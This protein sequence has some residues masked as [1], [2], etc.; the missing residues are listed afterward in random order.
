[1][2]VSHRYRDFGGPKKTSGADNSSVSEEL[3]D[4]KLKAFEAGYQAG[5][6]DSLKAKEGAQEKLQTELSQSLLD[7]SFTYHEAL[8]KLTTSFEAV[9][10]EVVSKLLPEVV[11]TS[12]GAHIVEQTKQMLAAKTGQ[13]VEIVVNPE[14]SAV[15]EQILGEH[16]DNP[17]A[18]V[19]E[20]TLSAG[21][22]FI[23][24]S[25]N[26][27]QIDLDTVIS[28]VSRALNGFFHETAKEAKNGQ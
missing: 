24:V 13:S 22:A 19:S 28:E 25:D 3:E 17:F 1:M 16:L 10:T 27:C 14:N 26:E 18:L 21:Q 23:R 7:A 8:A 11:K 4:Q 12:L 15:M 5:W 2:S 20:D 6:D 9:M